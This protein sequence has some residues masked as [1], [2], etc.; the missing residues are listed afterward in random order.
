MKITKGLILVLAALASGCGDNDD[1]DDIGGGGGG[2]GG[3][4][5]DGGG[6][7]P[8]VLEWRANLTP[9]ELY[10]T[11]RGD[12]LVR[13]TVG[14]SAFTAAITI[15]EDVAGSL[16][17]WHVHTGN[18]GAG[19]GIV[20]AD[21]A[22]PRLGVGSDGAATSDVLIRV[23]LDANAAYSVNVHYS[24]AEFARIIACGNLVRQ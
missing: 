12:A 23:G 20:G 17:P 24:D 16:R 7:T 21:G 11:I 5:T 1:D 18:C 6:T 2:G 8:T 13:M 19:G 15:R 10:A 3:G 22:Y 9:T 4:G 14:E